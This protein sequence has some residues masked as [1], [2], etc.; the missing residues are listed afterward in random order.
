MNQR[1]RD[2]KERIL[3]LLRIVIVVISHMLNINELITC[4]YRLRRLA[5]LTA[6]ALCIGLTLWSS[7]VTAQARRSTVEQQILQA[8]DDGNYQR[9]VLL[10]EEHLKQRPNDATMLYNL[11][12]AHCLLKDMD[13][14]AAA[15]HR[16]FRSGFRDVNHMRSDPDLAGLREHPVYRTILEEADIVTSRRAANA[17]QE[18]RDTYGEEHYRYERDEQHRLNFATALDDVSHKEMREMLERQADQMIATL[19]EHP[20]GYD[21]LI[22]VP[23]PADSDKFFD[24]RS[25][26]GM[27]Q[28]DMRRLVARDIG[29]TLRHEF[30]HAMHYGH[31]ERLNQPHALWVQEGLASLYEEYELD[32]DGTIRFLPNDRQLIVKS[33]ARTGRLTP[34]SELFALTSREFMD[35]AQPLYPTVRSIFEYV[36]D[37]GKLV[38]WY[39]AYIAHFG[40]DRTGAKAFEVTF[41]KPVDTVEKDWRRWVTDQ[42][43]I[44]LNIRPE[45]AALGVRINDTATNDGVLVTDVISRSSAA[46]AGLRRGDVIVAV[47]D[48]STRSLVDLRKMIASKSDGDE[49]QVR[50]RRNGEYITAVIVLRPVPGT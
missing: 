6:L 5:R 39:R 32:D 19:F 25:V 7:D 15:L 21:V 26:G 34:W 8:F 28:H 22:A 46:V 24:D 18:W 3:R 31:M 33:R 16:A 13:A 20:P 14:S 37:Q 45:R 50:F 36:A 43:T 40:D 11:A 42:P 10:I 44:N 2:R 27:Y 9:A 23:T 35:K 12:C 41:G 38:E 49:L 30:F 4:W 1:F 48:R 17:L 29:A 47:D